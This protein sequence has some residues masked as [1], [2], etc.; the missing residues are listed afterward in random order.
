MR[1]NNFGVAKHFVV[2]SVAA[3]RSVDYLALLGFVGRG[4]H[5]NGLVEL[6]VEILSR[7]LDRLDAV[8]FEEFDELVVSAPFLS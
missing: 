7:A 5:G 3:G 2:D 1:Y 8:G 4:N 6:G